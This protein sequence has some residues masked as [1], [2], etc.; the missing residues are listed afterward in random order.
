MLLQLS[1]LACCLLLLL[2]FC[3]TLDGEVCRPQKSGFPQLLQVAIE[4]SLNDIGSGHMSCLKASCSWQCCSRCP[5]VI[6]S[7]L[8]G[9]ISDSPTLN[10]QYMWALSLLCPVLSL[11]RMTWSGL[12]SLWRLFDWLEFGCCR[13]HF[14]LER[15]L[16]M[17]FL[18]VQEVYLSSWSNW[19]PSLASQSACLFP[20][21]LQWAG[22]HCGV[23][24]VWTVRSTRAVS[25]SFRSFCQGFWSLLRRERASVKMTTL[26]LVQ[27]R[28]F[29]I[30]IATFF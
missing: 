25:T 30:S 12:F 10:L 16:M 26:S 8:H 22:V 14:F 27:G 19:P 7:A 1:T 21:I 18:S 23:R 11:N 15:V 2:H 5:A 9:H 13:F 28:L 20:L 4:L 3:C 17:G 29:L 24:F 6:I